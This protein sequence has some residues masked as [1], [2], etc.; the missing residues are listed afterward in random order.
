MVQGRHEQEQATSIKM[1]N[2]ISE[3]E[4]HTRGNKLGDV[5]SIKMLLVRYM[6]KTAEGKWTLYLQDVLT[7]TIAGNTGLSALL[8]TV[9]MVGPKAS[10]SNG[11][12]MRYFKKSVKNGFTCAS[13]MKME[14]TTT[15]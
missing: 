8:R 14:Y 2:F 6:T 10:E 1:Y 9:R 5:R 13:G 11:H 12:P 3:D 7:G 15:A 4:Y